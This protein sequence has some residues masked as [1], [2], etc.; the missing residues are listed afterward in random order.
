MAVHAV[1]I[2]PL[3][4]RHLPAA[5][6]KVIDSTRTM[7]RLSEHSWSGH[8]FGMWTIRDPEGTVVGTSGAIVTDQRVWNLGFRL[9]PSTWGQGLASEL[10]RLAV[11]RA[12]E[13]SPD[14]PVTARMVATNPGSVRVAQKAG[15]SLAWQGRSSVGPD[16]LVYAD[17][18]LD[19][20]TLDALIALG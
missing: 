20:H 18:P 5:R 12:R 6:P 15:L 14:T 3:T 7:I 9:A 4:W 8:G 16:R 13:A 2:D 11:G 19:A 10:A 1:Q 17:R